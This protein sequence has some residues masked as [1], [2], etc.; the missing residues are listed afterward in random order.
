MAFGS[1]AGNDEVATNNVILFLFFFFLFFSFFSFFFFPS[2][3]F[4]IEGVLRSK[5]LLSESC[6]ERP[7]RCCYICPRE[8]CPRRPWSKGTNVQETVVQRDFGPRRLLSKEAFISDKRAQI[9]SFYS[10]LDITILIDYKMAKNNMKSPLC[11][12]LSPWT[13]VSLDQCFLGQKSFWTN[14]P[15]TKWS[16]LCI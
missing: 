7:K 14:V 6:L 16:L 5:N 12:K 11:F 3:T 15:W 2:S 1:T 8:S 10:L 4:L 13:K 9:I